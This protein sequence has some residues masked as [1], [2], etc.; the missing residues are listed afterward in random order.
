MKVAFINQIS[1]ATWLKTCYQLSK[2]FAELEEHTAKGLQNSA[3]KVIL[4]T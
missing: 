2:N 3:I 4:H 1:A